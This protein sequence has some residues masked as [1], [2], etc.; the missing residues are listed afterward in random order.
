MGCGASVSPERLEKTTNEQIKS[1]KNGTMS[2]LSYQI[3]LKNFYFVC[4][5]KNFYT[6]PLET[7]LTIID[8]VGILSYDEC[9]TVL[10]NV[11]LYTTPEESIPQVMRQY[12]T[13]I[14]CKTN[15]PETGEAVYMPLCL[16][17]YLWNKFMTCK[18]TTQKSFY[19]NN[20]TIDFNSDQIKEK[21]QEYMEYQSSIPRIKHNKEVSLVLQCNPIDMLWKNNITSKC[22][23]FENPP[24][25]PFFWEH[26]IH[27]AAYEAQ[28]KSFL[29][30]LYLVPELL[31]LP[32]DDGNTPG[33]YAAK[34]NN[35]EILQLLHSF[36]ANLTYSNKKGVLPMHLITDINVIKMMTNLGYDIN[37][38]SSSGESILE[39]R[40]RTFNQNVVRE[41]LKSGADLFDPNPKGTLW[42]QTMI[43][44]KSYS[45]SM[46]ENEFFN[47]VKECVI[48]NKTAKWNEN[49]IYQE[50]IK[51]KNDN[52]NI[53]DLEKAVLAQNIERINILLGLGTNP[54]KP[55]KNNKTNLMICAEKNFT[56]VGKILV[57]N[58]CDPNFLN[59]EKKS[60]FYIA[61]FNKNFELAKE[62][63]EY[64]A[65][66][67]IIASDGDT[68]LHVAYKNDWSD[69]LNFLLEAGAD[70]NIPGKDGL[71]V[72]FMAFLENYDE[73]AEM[74]QDKYHGLIFMLNG[75]GQTLAH[76]AIR[77]KNLD[78]LKYLYKRGMLFGMPNSVGNTPLHEAF[79]VYSSFE[80]IEYLLSQGAKINTTNRKGDN[81]LLSV[82]QNT[83]IK[84]EYL[85]FLYEH[86]IDINHANKEGLT[87]LGVAIKRNL[88][89]IGKQL[90]D[91]NCQINDENNPNEP[92]VIAIKEKKKEWVELLFKRGAKAT[93]TKFNVLAEYIKSD[94]FNFQTL[95]TISVA[96]LYNGAP[97]QVALLLNKNDVARFLWNFTG[98]DSTRIELSK[99]KGPNGRIPLSVAILQK[100]NEFIKLLIN[101]KYDCTTPDDEG[102]TPLMHAC[103]VDIPD[104]K[105]RYKL[106]D[107]IGTENANALD[108]DDCSAL[109]YAAVYERKE[110]AN[111]LFI[112]NVNI[113]NC[114]IDKFGIIKLYRQ[115]EEYRENAINLTEIA[116]STVAKMYNDI[117]HD[118]NKM[119][120]IYNE[121]NHKLQ[122]AEY[123]SEI[124]QIKTTL[125]KYSGYI[126]ILRED[127][128]TFD[129]I[130]DKYK[131]RLN[132]IKNTPRKKLLEGIECIERI[133]E[134]DISYL[135]SKRR[136]IPDFN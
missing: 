133:T 117:L 47:L 71:T 83:T 46:E 110:F 70:P 82:L 58:Y 2:D 111:Y 56:D 35:G 27:E 24:S 1:L 105:D 131:D 124:N 98:K 43:H 80:I 86:K 97:L 74:L 8:D 120:D 25:K 15:L 36:G 75:E 68:I 48:N 100:N 101:S 7:A 17:E 128:E 44:N 125:R 119:I 130:Y 78:R 22:P 72:T 62:M 95:K 30:D 99:N 104:P 6:L 108:S 84:Q 31:D 81:I 79:V 90:L 13:R 121:L 61:V 85:N 69:C 32:D 45:S 102:L 106:F 132:Q 54:D 129:K 38:R 116:V 26:S 123:Q 19:Q 113:S 134:S 39:L 60:P 42:I 88:F 33:H 50:I 18:Y 96:N 73:F 91:M 126:D 55:N 112:N 92:I 16:D 59:N 21:R 136:F 122:Y 94:I 135:L 37:Q 41:L 67:N 40:T 29:Y 53:A 14:V 107:I 103:I 23:S 12:A 89:D 76:I 118:L 28:R 52:I 65:N 114:K 9:K 20:D 93:N 51:R 66:P 77:Q 57:N 64:K 87:P 49:K 63:V 34:G 3:F 109:T 5:I 115:L 11:C 10:S 127:L 4:T